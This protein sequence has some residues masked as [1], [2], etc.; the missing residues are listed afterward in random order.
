MRAPL[1]KRREYMQRYKEKYPERF[2]RI[3]R[4]SH[5]RWVAKNREHVREWHRQWRAKNRAL[6][7]SE[8]K[9]RDVNYKLIEN[10]RT[11][12]AR[13]VGRSNK[14][15]PTAKL[16]GCSID[17]LKLYLESKF[18]DGMTWENYGSLWHIDH[19]IP[20]ALFDFTKPIHQKVCFHFSNLQPLLA[21]ENIKKGA[22]I[23]A[24]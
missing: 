13:A 5:Y 18:E 1:H 15:A 14:S 12:I 16:I 21:A 24:A 10:L 17:N 19:I 9:Q 23:K 7:R 3:M 6:Y 4:E 11:R 22:R 20:C 2:K 8:R